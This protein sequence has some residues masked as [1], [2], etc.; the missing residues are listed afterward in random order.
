MAVPEGRI[1]HDTLPSCTYGRL[2]E[3]PGFLG[4]PA[5][6]RYRRP[7]EIRRVEVEAGVRRRQGSRIAAPPEAGPQGRA[8]L[9]VFETDR[10][11]IRRWDSADLESM[12]RILGDPEVMCFSD[13]VMDAPAVARWLQARIDQVTVGSVTGPWAIVEKTG[14][15]AIGYCGF[16]EY[17]D[18]DGRPETEIGYRLARDA[19][20]QGYA[21]E[22][23]RAT[24]NHGF[25]VFGL[26]RLVALIDPD[27]VRS[28]RV[29]ERIGMRYE[30]DVMLEGYTY[31]D[32][33]YA[34]DSPGPG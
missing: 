13:G 4:L 14:D 9:V 3:M 31:A 5:E 8:Q 11:V 7:A 10:L 12:V 20:G 17:P 21:T 23:A 29:A 15:S 33:L 30:K 34:I 19:W 25:D 1:Q 32:R 16:F 6:E 28:I 18:I 27:N 2:Q 22:A 26:T 24:R